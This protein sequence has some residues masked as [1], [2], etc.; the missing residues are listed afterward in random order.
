[1]KSYGLIEISDKRKWEIVDMAK[2]YLI[3][4]KSKELLTNFSERNH[5][6]AEIESIRSK[7]ED[8]RLTVLCYAMDLTIIEQFKQW[9]EL[10]QDVELIINE[11]I[12]E[13]N[14]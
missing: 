4:R 9:E 1:M 12:N 10:Q 6:K 11:V 2:D 7:G 5:I 13:N 3:N 14:I 8:T